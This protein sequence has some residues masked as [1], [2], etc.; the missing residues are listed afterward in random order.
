MKNEIHHYKDF[1]DSILYF[2]LF[3]LQDVDQTH[4]LFWHQERSA[5]SE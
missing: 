2:K 4:F 3:L 1:E 5:S